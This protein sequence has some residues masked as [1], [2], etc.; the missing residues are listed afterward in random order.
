MAR[1]VSVAAVSAVVIIMQAPWG[2]G[3][4]EVAKLSAYHAHGL[5]GFFRPQERFV[6]CDGRAKAEYD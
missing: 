2:D 5:H 1:M 4:W 3:L 6:V